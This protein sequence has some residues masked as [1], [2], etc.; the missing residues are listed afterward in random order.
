MNTINYFETFKKYR[1]NLGAGVVDLEYIKSLNVNEMLTNINIIY[2]APILKKM[3]FYSLSHKYIDIDYLKDL[4]P[5]NE[6]FY[7]DTKELSEACTDYLNILYDEGCMHPSVLR[8]NDLDEG[9]AAYEN[10]LNHANIIDGNLDNYNNNVI[11]SK[12]NNT[13]R[14]DADLDY[15]YQQ[16]LFER[17]NKAE[18]F[19][20]FNFEMASNAFLY[21]MRK[22]MYDDCSNDL[23]YSYDNNYNVG[24]IVRQNDSKQVMKFLDF[25][26][27]MNEIDENMEESKYSEDIKEIIRNYK[28]YCSYRN[29][30]IKNTC[31][32]NKVLSFLR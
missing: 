7:D 13:I 16:Q 3:A 21:S 29:S 26:I 18:N 30:Y 32:E 8:Y 28:L 24:R 23:I 27:K 11:V 4:A 12:F 15:Y 31:N 6:S 17:L 19:D 9:V 2:I 1:K 20:S 10:I 5:T 22:L 25:M 14:K